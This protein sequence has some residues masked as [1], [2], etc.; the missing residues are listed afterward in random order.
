MLGLRSFPVPTR[1]AFI[2]EPKD[3][4]RDV[5]GWEC[6][7]GISGWEALRGVVAENV[8]PGSKSKRADVTVLRP[9][10]TLGDAVTDP[11]SGFLATSS[12]CSLT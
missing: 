6:A 3:M 10:R 4:Q 1:Y 9:C 7:R 12:L 8:R 5:S 2:T 11:F